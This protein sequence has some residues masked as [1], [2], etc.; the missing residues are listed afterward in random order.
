MFHNAQSPSLVVKP[1][2]KTLI[3]LCIKTDPVFGPALLIAQKLSCVGYKSI[4]ICS[5]AYA[6]KFK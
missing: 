5:H 3:F 6:R 1:L 2:Q 4:S